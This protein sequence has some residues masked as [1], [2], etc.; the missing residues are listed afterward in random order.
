VVADDAVIA[1]EKLA[2]G[3]LALLGNWVI[4]S[5]ES[6]G[7]A[8]VLCWVEVGGGYACCTFCTIEIWG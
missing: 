6:A 1:G 5:A 7:D 3:T 2:L 8:F 4:Y